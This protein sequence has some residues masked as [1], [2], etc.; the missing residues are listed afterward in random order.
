MM[1]NQSLR[2][3]WRVRSAGIW[4]LVWP[5]MLSNLSVPLLGAVDTAI[6]GHLP[7]AA[8]LGA[9]AV[10]SSVITMVFW[11]LGFLRM[12]TTSLVSR[13]VGRQDWEDTLVL[14]LR[15][16]ALALSL[17]AVLLLCRGWIV[18][19]AMSWM[20]PTQ[21]SLTLAASYSGIRFW[22]APATLI[23]YTII[24]WFIGHQDT[25]SPLVI[26]LVT[27]ALNITLDFLFV[28]GLGLASDGAAYASVVAEYTGLVCGLWM[29]RRRVLRL[30]LTQTWRQRLAHMRLWHAYLPL[31]HINRH[32]FV[33]TA[34]LLG[35]FTFFTAQGARA[36]TN[37]VAANA[38]LLQLLM[39]TSHALDGF[40]HAAEALCGKATGARDRRELWRVIQATTVMAAAS[41]LLISLIF[42]LSK[43]PLL[44][45]FTTLPTV[46][47]EANKQFPWVIALPLIAVWGYQLD[48]IFIGMGMTRAMQFSMAGCML[49]VFFPAWW[50]TTDW[51]N[52]G[53]W[54]AFCLFNLTRGLSM[55]WVLKRTLAR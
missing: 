15:S 24:G 34:C 8:Y 5:I 4:P 55:A 29:L 53:L 48:G 44:Q 16:V 47:S 21:E 46:L 52:T 50:L 45:L 13:A 28:L 1:Q 20:K 2:K 27:N 7:S 18:E 23:N 54:F 10:G 41:A 12:G 36:G 39:L 25:R 38:I 30:P 37:I 40:A 32:L 31:L 43:D 19:L 42:W 9:V 35:V 17:A 51:H 22:S 6:L 11:S 3:R 33:R 26:L 14:W 49:L